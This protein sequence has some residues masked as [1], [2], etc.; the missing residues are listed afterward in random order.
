M[1]RKILSVFMYFIHTAWTKLSPNGYARHVGVNLG[2]NVV[3]YGMK[4]YMFNTEPWIITIGDNCHITSNCTFITHD[5][6]TLILRKEVPDLELTGPITIGNDV[7]IGVNTTI[8]PDTKI[9]NRCIVGAC[10][11][12]RG[13][14]PD[15]SVIAGNPARVIK[16]VDKY[17]EKAKE[18]SL[19]VGHLYGKEKDKELRKI[20][21]K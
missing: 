6:G 18:K 13:T 4:P 2:E 14:F 8:L 10:S 7:Y 11:L 9:G 21:N 3:F 16:T 20:F 1:L 15:N 17:L 12:V 19:H 5:G